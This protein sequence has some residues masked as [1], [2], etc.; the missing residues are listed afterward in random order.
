V[1]IHSNKYFSIFFKL[2]LLQDVQHKRSDVWTTLNTL[3]SII[4]CHFEPDISF[5]NENWSDIFVYG[6]NKGIHEEV[7]PGVTFRKDSNVVERMA[8][9]K[10]TVRRAIPYDDLVK[11][12]A[13][14]VVP[15][16]S[17]LNCSLPWVVALCTSFTRLPVGG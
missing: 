12:I 1:V 6:S 10:G 5:A 3:F 2:I 16:T 17:F 15:Y 8:P 11:L 14:Q 13:M 9:K 4:F 7:L